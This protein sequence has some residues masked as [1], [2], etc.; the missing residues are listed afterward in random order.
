M[1]ENKLVS[2]LKKDA[3]EGKVQAIAEVTELFNDVFHQGDP[4]YPGGMAEAVPRVT[5]ER[6]KDGRYDKD[7]CYRSPW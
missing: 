7:G 1:Y 6:D 5:L 3:L 4:Y 2:E